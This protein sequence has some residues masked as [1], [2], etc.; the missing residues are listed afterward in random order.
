M[1]L[2]TREDFNAVPGMAED[3]TKTIKV[4][5][6]TLLLSLVKLLVTTISTYPP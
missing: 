3:L 1:E 5:W 4:P 6:R 2:M